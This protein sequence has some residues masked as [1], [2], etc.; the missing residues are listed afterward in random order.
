MYDYFDEYKKFQCK[1]HK[2]AEYINKS[3]YSQDMSDM[4]DYQYHLHFVNY[5]KEL[6]F[7]IKELENSIDSDP[8]ELV[9]QIN[10]LD[11]KIENKK[12]ELK[13]LQKEL[14][15][16]LDIINNTSEKSAKIME[17]AQK[18]L[19][20]LNDDF[21]RHLLDKKNELLNEIAAEKER[22]EQQIRDQE[23]LLD[24]ES[25]NLGNRLLEIIKREAVVA[26]KEKSLG[27]N[28]QAN[29]SRKIIIDNE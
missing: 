3:Y 7:K 18:H 29:N 16:S 2:M 12:K 11:D 9:K 6:E 24:A 15:E 25:N 5:I 17:N 10:S 4:N 20:R 1:K 19:D 13:K 28:N 23:R 8:D 26:S 27:I 14:S 22:M 21:D